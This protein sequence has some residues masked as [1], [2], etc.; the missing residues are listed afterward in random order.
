MSLDSI[1]PIFL[2]SSKA[3]GR[4]RSKQ[5]TEKQ[6]LESAILRYNSVA[7][8]R[9]TEEHRAEGIWPWQSPKGIRL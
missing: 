8:N 3:R 2:V 9:V 5:S 6:Q 4:L 1:L 7:T